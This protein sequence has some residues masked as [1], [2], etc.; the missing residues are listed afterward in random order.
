MLVAAGGRSEM[1]RQIDKAK[2]EDKADF[3][4]STSVFSRVDGHLKGSVR[5]K[6]CDAVP[7]PFAYAMFRVTAEASPYSHEGV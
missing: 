5:V 3:S 2:C 1:D 7:V 4:S 6:V